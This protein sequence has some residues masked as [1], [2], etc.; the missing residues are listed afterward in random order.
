[1]IEIWKDIPFIS[2]Y[3]ASNFGRIKI[4]SKIVG[5]NGL[6][7]KGYKRINI[8]SKVYQIHRLIAITFIENPDNKP[9]VNHIDGNKLNN[10]VYNLEWVTN[11]ENRDHAIKL[12]L[13]AN[14]SNGLKH[15]ISL[16]DCYKIKELY[17]SKLFT[18]TELGIKY[19][20]NRR[21]IWKIID[22]IRKGKFLTM[23]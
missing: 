23:Q 17:D 13:H 18:S 12:N 20:V 16:N 21:T 6:S 22:R 8:R 10:N 19:N 15:K 14:R 7:R 5:G 2:D 1:M 9:Q 11:Q 3:Q 4:L